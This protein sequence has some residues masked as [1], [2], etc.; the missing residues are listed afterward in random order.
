MS[1]SPKESPINLSK[2]LMSRYYQASLNSFNN[3]VIVGELILEKSW[4]IVVL[5]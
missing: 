1:L 2:I 4:K 5:H 3:S